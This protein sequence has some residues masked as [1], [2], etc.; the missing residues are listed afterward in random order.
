MPAKSL[1]DYRWPPAGAERDAAFGDDDIEPPV[2]VP[3]DE[4]PDMPLLPMLPLLPILPLSRP[5]ACCRLWAFSW[6]AMLSCDDDRLWRLVCAAR[7]EPLDMPE[8]V[9][10]WLLPWLDIEP[11]DPML[12]DEPLPAAMPV[13]DEDRSLPD[14]PLPDMPLDDV[15][16]PGRLPDDMLFVGPPLDIVLDA[17]PPDVMLLL[18]PEVPLVDMLLPGVP[19]ED[20]LLE[21][22]P[23]DDVPPDIPLDVPPEA[24]PDD[25][26]PLWALAIAGTAA[27]ASVQTAA[28]RWCFI[29]D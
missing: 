28:S 7:P 3:L 11:C 8:F 20:M 1:A 16:L 27:K 22:M 26:P 25:E 24:P 19:L 13:P 29:I 12:P 17:V 5:C 15:L 2:P 9:D 14:M 10:M 21:G 23:L 18:V 4:E 6:S